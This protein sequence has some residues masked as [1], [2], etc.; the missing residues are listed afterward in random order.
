MSLEEILSIDNYCSIH[1]IS[2]RQRLDELHL[3]EGMYYSS[4]R[5]LLAKGV[6]PTNPS[7]SFVKLSPS[8]S[9]SCSFSSSSSSSSSSSCVSSLDG[10]SIEVI[11]PTGTSVRLRGAIPVAHLQTILSELSSHVLFK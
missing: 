8:S 2:R 9:S 5:R 4:K 10:I 3:T 7:T 11:Y 1:Q 6:L